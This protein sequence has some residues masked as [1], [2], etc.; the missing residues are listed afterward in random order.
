[1][2]PTGPGKLLSDW[3]VFVDPWQKISKFLLLVLFTADISLICAAVFL[4]RGRDANVGCFSTTSMVSK[5]K[6]TNNVWNTSSR[7]SVSPSSGNWN[8]V[9]RQNETW[10]SKCYTRI[11]ASVN[12][13]GHFHFKSIRQKIIAP[14]CLLR[15]IYNTRL[16]CLWP[17]T[18]VKEWVEAFL[19]SIFS[20]LWRQNHSCDL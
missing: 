20:K 18:Y 4:T 9:H 5:P 13:Y 19:F 14:K 7:G 2:R 8:H 12:F 16:T 3:M 15:A 17:I 6:Q 1:M 11:F 10:C